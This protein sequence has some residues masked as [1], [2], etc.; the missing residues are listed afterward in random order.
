MTSIQD[1]P[2][3]PIRADI[4]EAISRND[5]A[6]AALQLA[7]LFRSAPTLANAQFVLDRVGK[8]SED[9]KPIACRVAFL[10]SF[11]IEPVM[12]L[13]R[14]EA[15]LYGVDINTHLGEFNTYA[16]E[17]LDPASPLYQFDPNIVVLAVQTRDLVPDL[18]SRFTDL[19]SVDAQ[20]VVENAEQTIRSLVDVFRSR[21][22]AHLIIHNLEEPAV[23]SAGIYDAQV[24]FGQREAIQKLNSAL[25]QVAGDHTG[26][27]VL[28]YGALVARH[29][30]ER[31]H[32]ERKWLTARMPISAD[33]L[34]YL[35]REYLRF[36]L[37]ITGKVCKAL[38]VDL[39]NT[40]W[41]GVIGEDG[42]EGIKIGAEYPGASFLALQ[43]AILDLSRRGII[44][45]V[46]SK[47]NFDDAMEAL[48]NHPEMLLRPEHFAALRIN[49]NDKA[50]S[51][52]EIAKEL[53]IGLDAV[54]FLD[55][56]PAERQR[57]QIDLPEAT[58]I[59]LPADPAAYASALRE[60]PVFE[61]LTLSDEDR[62]RG[63]LYAEQRQR[64]E[65]EASAGTLEDYYRSLQMEVEIAPVSS[66]T[67]ARV[68]QLTQK[69]N[70]FNMTTRRYSEQ[71]IEQLAADPKSRVCAVRVRDRFG[72][73]GLV[74]VTIVRSVDKTDEVDTFL[75]S[76]RV[77]GRTIE[78]AILS[79]LSQSAKDR[80]ATVL[81]G[82][83][84]PTKKNAPAKDAY[85][86]HGFVKTEETD[87]SISWSLD[88]AEANIA[89]PEWIV[90]RICGKESD[91]KVAFSATGGANG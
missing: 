80:G 75:L 91:E 57:I 68:A 33:S 84:I 51:L 90:L 89:C 13:L 63:R 24:A 41:G 62:E 81:T 7:Q 78:T 85:S 49:W 36:L 22:K 58:V 44:L 60:S 72:D 21:S 86:A 32:D 64:A 88:L 87:D 23:S 17:I 35:A 50:Q 39:D 54:A 40:L 12:P 55:D 77:I 11:T 30:R 42:M 48:S 73:N 31:W 20:A 43:R 28:D 16:Q 65:L 67:L 38:A 29:G 79:Y 45:A 71:E 25:R 59:D 83:F 3:L 74:G 18:W 19:S 27:Y 69:T 2:Q 1:A 70:Q 46:A 53:N 5:P 9:R 34:I 14:A 6:L 4:D 10:R 37:P 26:V 8:T 82:Q 76:C 47:N 61:R 56:N 15:A 66:Q 52:R